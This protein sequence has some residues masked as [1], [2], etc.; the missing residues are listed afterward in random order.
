MVA[1]H[2]S[3]VVVTGGTG[4]LGSAVVGALR[5]AGADMPRHQFGRRRARPHYP[6]RDDPRRA[7][8]DRPRPRRRGGGAPVLRRRC[9]RSG[10]RC[11]WP[12]GS[13]WRRSPRSRRSDFDDQFQMN[14]LSC[15]SVLGGGD[16]GDPARGRAGRRQGRAHRQCRGA[17]GP[18]AAARRRDGRLCRVEG[19]RRG[20]DPGDGRGDSPARKSGSTRSRRRSSTRRPTARRCPTPTH[21]R[22]VDA[23]AVAEVIAFLASPDNKVDPRRGDPGLWRGVMA[24][25]RS[26]PR[27]AGVAA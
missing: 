24:R 7:R 1:F 17:P 11:I 14:A 19:R 15:V 9:R 10:P 27:S 5:A 4:A 23:G 8:H 20:A 25:L 18:G 21:D 22:W 6:H 12:A 26:P 16:A 2:G 3:H 13:R